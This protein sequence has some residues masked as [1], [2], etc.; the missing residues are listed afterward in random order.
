MLAPYPGNFMLAWYEPWKSDNMK[1]GVITIQ[2]KPVAHDVFRQLY[3][4]RKLAFENLNRLK[5]PLWDPYNG[6]GQ[7]IFA[8]I[9]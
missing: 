2:H 3:P 4:I 5:V 1:N 6:S 9:S 8:T 7:P